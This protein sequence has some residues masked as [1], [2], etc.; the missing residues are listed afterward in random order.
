M[1]DA[2]T[3]TVTKFPDMRPPKNR[4][5]LVAPLPALSV[6]R[7]S[8]P[9]FPTTDSAVGNQRA[10]RR[11]LIL[12]F[13]VAVA[14]HAVLLLALW[15]TP[16]LRLKWGPSSDSWVHVI[17]LPSK[18]PDAPRPEAG[19]ASKTVPAKVKKAQPPVDLPSHPP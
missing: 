19:A 10:E 9:P 12:W 14:V 15:L 3:N 4:E 13:G 18:Q 16:P 7:R 1:N 11:R 6:Y 8:A 17:S 2:P 5:A